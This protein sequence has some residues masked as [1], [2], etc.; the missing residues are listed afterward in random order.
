M[1]IKIKNSLKFN[2]NSRPLIIAEISG[3]HSGNKKKFLKLIKEAY[4]AGADLVK[5]QTYEPKDITIN[6]N[7]KPFLIKNGIW[8]NK[9]LWNIYQSAHT[10][11]AWHEDAFK[12][13]NRMN[14][15]LFSSPFSLRAVDLLEK[16]KVPIYKISSFEIT[17]LKLINY[18]ARKKKPIIISTGMSEISEV[19]SA[20]K[21]INKFH[22]KII[23]LH[24]VSDY[25]TTLKNTELY[26]IKEL[27]KTFKNY[28]IGISDHTNDNISSL[29]ASTF[30]IVAIEKHFKLN[31]KE[32]TIDSKF[33]IDTKQLKK[34]K[35]DLDDIFF[36]LKKR[37]KRIKKMI[38]VRRSIF[39]KKDIKKNQKLSSQNIE[40]FRP[41]IGISAS[42]FFKILGK[43]SKRNIK[44]FKPIFKTDVY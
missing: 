12:L 21:E 13:A 11:F 3:N 4:K 16:M 24:C 17:D 1:K 43:K 8:K 36:S 20:I 30:R 25:P 38:Y 5:I 42:E 18:I 6:S 23:I 7:S 40:T 22:K 2:N 29:I 44:A 19:K 31:S 27:K 10:P 37:K 14:K 26:K 33:S 34:L 35:N 39:A 9:S 15:V 41:K 32:K 28:L